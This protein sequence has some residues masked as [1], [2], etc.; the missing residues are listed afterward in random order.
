MAGR[1]VR[2][3][4]GIK[5]ERVRAAL[6]AAGL[7]KLLDSPD[8]LPAPVEM[9]SKHAEWRKAVRKALGNEATDGIAAKLINVYLKIAFVCGGHHA[10]PRVAALHPPI[11]RLLLD[12]LVKLTRGHPLHQEFLT[13]KKVCW[14]KFTPTQYEKVIAAIRSYLGDQP[15]WTIEEHWPGNQ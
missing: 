15:L 2:G 7:N 6:E 13:A 5:V 14:T 9:D 3:I 11:D 1:S 10:H 4:S 12:E 8:K